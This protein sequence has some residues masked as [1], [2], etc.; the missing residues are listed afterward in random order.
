MAADKPTGGAGG[1]PRPRVAAP[2]KP[3]TY[4]GAPTGATPPRKPSGPPAA[5]A[6]AAP[7]QAAAAPA[8]ASAGARSPVARAAPVKAAPQAQAK[9]LR[10]A[11][12]REAVRLFALGAALQ[13]Q[14]RLEDSTR[15]YGR[16]IMF[17]PDF[18]DAYANL[19]VALRAQGKSEAAVACHRRALALKPDG[20]NYHSN[21]GNALRDLGHLEEAAAA[22][23]QALRLAPDAPEILYNF[24]LVLRD[25]GRLDTALSCF[26]AVLKLRPEHADCRYDRALTLL[27]AGDL[28]RGF[29]EYESRWKLRRNPPR[30]FDRPR[31]NGQAIPGKTLLI[32]A[33]PGFGD[34]IQFARYAALAKQKS[35]A[36][37]VLECPAE[38]AR[39]M[40]TLAAVDRIAIRGGPLP[41]FDAHIPIMSLPALMETTARNVPAAVPYLKAPEIRAVA[42]PELTPGAFKVGI[43][44]TGNP[45]ARADRH[46]SCPFVHFLDLAGISGVA[47]YSLQTGEAARDVRALA[48]EPLIFEAG[49]ALAD[50][51]DLAT[52][53]VQLDLVVSVDTATAHLAGA[54]GKPVWILLSAV[55][56]WRWPAGGEKTPWYPTMRL[57][58]QKARGDWTEVMTDVCAQL[59]RAVSARATAR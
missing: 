30:P 49:Q 22:L 48:A 15:A 25:M 9:A 12:G 46:R 37:V 20:A 21:L 17:N 16:A 44:W 43:V 31:W 53:L 56:D 27:R 10:E 59:Q 42:L 5:A 36:A 47:V 18:P 55:P 39:L 38:L 19:G 51:A 58:R 57:F 6:R 26:E 41:A 3:A 4:V 35:G 50:F 11:R 24:G 13:R 7:P 33:E 45:A 52:A 40:E 2:A 34:A 1:T 54:L 28:K 14:G 23:Q 32:H 29:A 8:K